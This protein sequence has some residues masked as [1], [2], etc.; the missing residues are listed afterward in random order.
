MP[1]DAQ[2]AQAAQILRNLPP[3]VAM[4]TNGLPDELFGRKDEWEVYGNASCNG[5]NL[6]AD[7]GAWGYVVAEALLVPHLASKRR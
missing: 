5:V 3:H 4:T 2:N 1:R 6:S 7:D